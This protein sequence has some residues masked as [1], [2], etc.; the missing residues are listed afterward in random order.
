[1]PL[2][3]YTTIKV[4]GPADLFIEAR[5]RNALETAIKEA[6][7][8]RVPYTV[9][10][11]GS[12]VLIGD[13][14]IRGLVIKNMTREIT[15]RGIKGKYEHGSHVGDVY[16]EADSGVIFNSLV[17]YCIEE[18]YKGI[19][20]HLGLPGT[21]GGAI[22]MNSKWTNPQG[23][24]GDVL[25]SADIITSEGEIRTVLRSY[26]QFSYDESILQKTKETVISATFKL[27][28][29]TKEQ[30]WD[31]ANRSIAYRRASQPQGV[32]SLG[33]TFQNIT[34]SQA[35]MIPTPLHTTSAGY[36][37]DRAGLKGY[38]IG[39]AQISPVH[40]NFIVNT[41]GATAAEIVQLIEYAK[42]E[43]RKKFGVELQEEIVR[44]GEF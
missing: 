37:L 28:K 1:V 16:V 13:K 33:C 22:Y 39:N 19:E 11:G 20:M 27:K 21:V 6:G 36:L 24:V 29:S 41:G 25:H 26:F 34:R 35:F 7:K 38:T 44:I 3:N 40:A 30:L 9:L 43:V 32:C 17:R 8:L 15:M 23:Y 42:G 5:T 14:G 12:N 31:I 4:G 10:G 2:A 18:G